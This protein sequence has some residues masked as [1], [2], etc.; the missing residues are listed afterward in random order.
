MANKNKN[1]KNTYE[2]P[3]F[4]PLK[5]FDDKPRPYDGKINRSEAEDDVWVHGKER[6][7]IKYFVTRGASAETDDKW[8]IRIGFPVDA[9][10][11]E[12]DS[13]EQGKMI[14][15]HYRKLFWKEFWAEMMDNIFDV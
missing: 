6:L 9:I 1:T 14:C 2:I 13:M 12:V 4:K 10:H 5:W 15:E 11:E 7:Y 8:Y 3:N